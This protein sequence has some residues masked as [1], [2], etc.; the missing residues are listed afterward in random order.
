MGNE[1]K[2]EV[3]KEMPPLCAAVKK[4]RQT[5]GNSLEA[6]ARQVGISINSASRFELAK[7]IPTDV[8]VLMKL[9][10][11]ANALGLPEEEKLFG[12]AYQDC[13]RQWT[14][15]KVGETRPAT[16][17]T[18]YGLEAHSMGMWR[19]MTA[20][21]ITPFSHFSRNASRRRKRPLRRALR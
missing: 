20:A 5:S 15:V 18:S 11:A 9:E 7:S 13:P 16:Q 2:R 21:Q 10:A 6:F 19:L 12:A 1:S 3:K 8:G 4:L 14:A 17:I